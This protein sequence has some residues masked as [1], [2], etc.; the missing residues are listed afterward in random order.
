MARIEHRYEDARGRSGI[1][2]TDPRRH[3]DVVASIGRALMS[4]VRPK[5]LATAQR[6][7]CNG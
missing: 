6:L 1:L 5:A 2:G 7:A 3:G 4:T